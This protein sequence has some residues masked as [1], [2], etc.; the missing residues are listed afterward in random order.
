MFIV[1]E[2]ETKYTSGNYFKKYDSDKSG[3]KRVEKNVELSCSAGRTSKEVNEN[4]LTNSCKYNRYHMLFLAILSINID[5]LYSSLLIVFSNP[6]KYTVPSPGHTNTSKI[7]SEMSKQTTPSMHSFLDSK[8]PS[9][10]N[11]F[12]RKRKL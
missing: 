1:I 7:H 2:K 4:H 3:G 5:A 10:T 6:E 12:R 8:I 9:R 11:G